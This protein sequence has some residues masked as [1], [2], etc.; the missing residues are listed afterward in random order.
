MDDAELVRKLHRV[1]SVQLVHIRGV[2]SFLEAR[3]E[4]PPMTLAEESAAL[5]DVVTLTA[6]AAAALTRMGC[7]G[8]AAVDR[9]LL[10]DVVWS[11]AFCQLAEIGQAAVGAKME[12]DSKRE[13]GRPVSDLTHAVQMLAELIERGGGKADATQ[14]GELCQAFGVVIEAAGL[15]I[16]N[17][18]ETV[19]AALKRRDANQ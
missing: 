6:Q 14:G 8:K 16:A 4:D 12:I 11:D 17:Q 18:R 5:L 3:R 15:S 1:P 19:R 9:R 2:I 13:A 7:R 10:S